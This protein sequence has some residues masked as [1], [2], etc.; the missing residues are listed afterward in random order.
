MAQALHLANGATIND[1]LRDPKGAVAGAI[2]SKATDAEVIDRLFLAALTRRPTGSERSR[3]TAVLAEA[4]A[5]GRR[6]AI[7]D[8]YWATMTGN[9]FLFN[10]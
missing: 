3:L 2:A 10:H 1:K 8:L 4:G 9:E 5:E 7:E 6:Q